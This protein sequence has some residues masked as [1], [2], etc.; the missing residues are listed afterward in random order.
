MSDNIKLS[1]EDMNLF[2]GNFH[3]LKDINMHIPEKEITGG[4]LSLLSSSTTQTVINMI[5]KTVKTTAHFPLSFILLFLCHI[6][7]GCNFSDSIYCSRI[8][9]NQFRL[10]IYLF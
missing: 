9:S 2:Y 7:S 3:A 4:F 10:Q 8:F 1:I 6:Y 5:F